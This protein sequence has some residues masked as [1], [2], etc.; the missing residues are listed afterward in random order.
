MLGVR[1]EV[2][3]SSGRGGGRWAP[4]TAYRGQIP[5]SS[6]GTQTQSGLGIE[7][8]TWKLGTPCEFVTASPSPILVE[9]LS[10]GQHFTSPVDGHKV[11]LE[12][13][14]RNEGRVSIPTQLW[15]RAYVGLVS[16]TVPKA[17]VT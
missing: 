1:L 3:R 15:F 17:E 10:V 12:T 14:G 8:R 13:M 11:N 6:A 9:R 4:G 16:G 7:E 5:E 2:S